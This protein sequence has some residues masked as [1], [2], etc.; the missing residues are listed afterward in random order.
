MRLFPA[1]IL[2]LVAQGCT[3]YYNDE[4][5]DPDLD[6]SDWWDVGDDDD[7]D[8]TDPDDTDTTDPDDTDPDG[9]DTGLDQPDLA[10]QFAFEPNHLVAGDMQVIRLVSTAEL[11]ASVTSIEILADTTIHA[12]EVVGD[13]IRV[14]VSVD[15]DADLGPAHAVLDVGDQTVFL[16][17]AL[18]ILDP[19]TVED[20]ACP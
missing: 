5:G 11:A 19:A 2:A 9:T 16:E 7:D 18:E 13:E 3:F 10:S 17:D 20:P 6:D 4:N 1:F 12:A 8:T 15:A 14:A